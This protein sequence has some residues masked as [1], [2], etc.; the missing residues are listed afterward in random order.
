V[1]WNE[2]ILHVTREKRGITNWVMILPEMAALLKDMNKRATGDLLFPSPFDAKKPRDVS[3]IRH[4][5]KAACKKLEIGHVAPHGLRSFFVTQARQSGLTDAEIA[6][7]AVLCP[8]RLAQPQLAFSTSANDSWTTL[9]WRSSGLG[10]FAGM[11]CFGQRSGT[12]RNLLPPASA[13]ARL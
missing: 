12:N 1:N 7:P 6:I 11:E 5:I 4:R 10:D 9:E 2:Q 3:A 8:A 13:A